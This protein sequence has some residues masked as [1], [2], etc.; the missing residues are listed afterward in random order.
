M[1]RFQLASTYQPQGDQPNAIRELVQ[2]LDMDANIRCCSGSL[3]QANL[4]MAN[5]IA[6]VNRP[7]W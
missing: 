5:M 3:A 7:T 6:R 4:T 1:D 2:G